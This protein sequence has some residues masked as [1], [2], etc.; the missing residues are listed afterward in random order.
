M[1]P[2]AGMQIRGLAKERERHDGR[3][4]HRHIRSYR[5]LPDIHDDRELRN[6]DGRR[7]Q[8]SPSPRRHEGRN[9]KDRDREDYRSPDRGQP[10][11]DSSPRRR[12]RSPFVGGTTAGAPS[13]EVI[14]EGLPLDITENDVRHTFPSRLP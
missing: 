8:R 14:L 11:G 6:Y 9:Y 7:Y 10:S 3:E 2:P 1:N 5:D 13:R 12:D 4:D